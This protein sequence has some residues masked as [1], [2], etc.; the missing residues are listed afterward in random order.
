[1]LSLF[2]SI[3][4][5]IY[6]IIAFIFCIAFIQEYII[7]I[8][9]KTDERICKSKFKIIFTYYICALIWPYILYKLNKDKEE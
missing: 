5:L 8:N 6:I 3:I 7:I 4:Y 9:I 1:M 2:L